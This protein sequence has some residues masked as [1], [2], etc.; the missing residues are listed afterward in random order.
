LQSDIFAFCHLPCAGCQ[1]ATA[2]SPANWMAALNIDLRNMCSYELPASLSA[3]LWAKSNRNRATPVR[4]FWPC[5]Q[6]SSCSAWPILNFDLMNGN[7]QRG[8]GG[9]KWIEMKWIRTHSKLRWPAISQR[10]LSVRFDN[11]QMDWSNWKLMEI[12]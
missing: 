7:L 3:A 10:E 5:Q 2:E 9:S 12:N 8:Q 11:I 6:I 4:P 1:H